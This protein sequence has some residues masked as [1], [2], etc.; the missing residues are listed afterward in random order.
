MECDAVISASRHLDKHAG[1]GM[2]REIV[3]ISSL[4]IAGWNGRDWE[5]LKR[6]IEELAKLGIKRS[7]KCLRRRSCGRRGDVLR[8]AGGIR[9]AQCFEMEWHDPV[10]GRS[11][12]HSYVITNLPISGE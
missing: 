9:P 2:R 6:H 10:L 11:L 5:A 4:T 8:N 7:A 3:A 1:A 12:R